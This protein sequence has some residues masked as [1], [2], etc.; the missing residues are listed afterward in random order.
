MGSPIR[1][2]EELE[3]LKVKRREIAHRLVEVRTKLGATRRDWMRAYRIIPSRMSQWETGATLPDMFVL[4]RI[5]EDHDGVSLD[6]ILNGKRP[7]VRVA[8]GSAP[9]MHKAEASADMT[10]AG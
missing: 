3:V 7:R 4:M 10:V 8:A 6:Y 2:S 9:A 1:T 5:C